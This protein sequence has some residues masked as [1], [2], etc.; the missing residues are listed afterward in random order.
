M[1]RFFVAAMYRSGMNAL[2]PPLRF[3][4]RCVPHSKTS[5]HS[6]TVS[7][8]PTIVQRVDSLSDVY[9]V[10]K[11]AFQ[12]RQGGIVLKGT[13]TNQAVAIEFYGP[14]SFGIAVEYVVAPNVTD[15]EAFLRGETFVTAYICHRL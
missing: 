6:T 15:A 13:K 9:D 1:T 7:T 8:Q 12:Q 10:A 4:V 5:T 11:A 2:E 14:A 3:P